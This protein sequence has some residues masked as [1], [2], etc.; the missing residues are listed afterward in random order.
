MKIITKKQ[1][2]FKIKVLQNSLTIALSGLKSIA[3]NGWD[4]TPQTTALN[5]ISSIESKYKEFTDY[6]NNMGLIDT[7]KS[8][9]E[10]K[11]EKNEF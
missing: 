2:E 4:E 1:L 5:S 10:Y 3:Y 9:C 6:L 7:T 11:G 8:I